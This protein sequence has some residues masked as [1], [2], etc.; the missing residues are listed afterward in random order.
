[1]KLST[2]LTLGGQPTH[3]VDHDI[4]LDLSAGGRASLTVEG[5]ATKG[6][7]LTVDTG[8]NGEM[9]RWFTGGLPRGSCMGRS[10]STRCGT[11][12]WSGA[13]TSCGVP[14]VPGWISVALI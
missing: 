4:V 1:M 13:V 11:A 5:T 9:R 6:Q 14:T 10:S 12:T 8:Y 2:S 7:T 3:L